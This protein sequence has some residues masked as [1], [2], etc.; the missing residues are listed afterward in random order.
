LAPGSK[1]AASDD[2]SV[3]WRDGLDLREVE[4]IPRAWS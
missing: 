4:T 3:R 1:K 2:V